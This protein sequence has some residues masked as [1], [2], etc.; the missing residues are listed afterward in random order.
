MPSD[1]IDE[2]KICRWAI[3]TFAWRWWEQSSLL[4]LCAN[5]PYPELR[6]CEFPFNIRS[7]LCKLM[8]IIHERRENWIRTGMAGTGA[9]GEMRWE[10]KKRKKEKVWIGI[11]LTFFMS[12]S[13]LSFLY[14]TLA[15][16]I[17]IFASIRTEYLLA[18]HIGVMMK[19][20]ICEKDTSDGKVCAWHSKFQLNSA[21]IKLRD[22]IFASGSNF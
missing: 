21:L 16:G 12:N 15:S 17:A 1:N 3:E 4:S 6:S 19:L 7:F 10:E 5:S 13:K 11:K 8:W 14:S 2:W 18:P 9:M 20:S 22:P